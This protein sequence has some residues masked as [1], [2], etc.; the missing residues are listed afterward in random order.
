M[1]VMTP[2]TCRAGRV[3]VGLT[4]RQ[5]AEASSVG[6]TT[7]KAYEAGISTPVT[8]NLA[9]MQAALER[10]GVVFIAANGGGVGVRL[11]TPEL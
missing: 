9:A 1:T 5:L 6:L 10:A 7:L 4:Q 2:K 8:N 3:L 11:K